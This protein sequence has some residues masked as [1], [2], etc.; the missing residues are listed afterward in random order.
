MSALPAKSDPEIA[1]VVFESDLDAA[2][3]TSRAERCGWVITRVSPLVAI[4]E[5][6]SGNGL[7]SKNYFVKLE[8]D[9]YNQFPPRVTFVAPGT[10]WPEAVAGSRWLPRLD[11]VQPGFAL[12]PSYTYPDGS[13]RQLI[14]SSINIEYYWTHEPDMTKAW[15]PGTTTLMWTLAVVQD[16]LLGAG[17]RGSSDALDS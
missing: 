5:M 2:M 6:R 14:C 7:E 16:E 8:A 9:W 3:R 11:N 10:S 17:Y 12:H 15:V 1:Q 4:V 13:A